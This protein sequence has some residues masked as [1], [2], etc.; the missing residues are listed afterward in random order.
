MKRSDGIAYVE[1]WD[2]VLDDHGPTLDD[3]AV[4]G[5]AG[6]S[7]VAPAAIDRS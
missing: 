7:R 4:P 6:V 2:R 1:S 3:P 5:P